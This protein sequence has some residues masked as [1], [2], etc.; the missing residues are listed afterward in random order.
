MRRAA[1]CDDSRQ[2]MVNLSLLA[3]F[4]VPA[5]GGWKHWLRGHRLSEELCEKRSTREIHFGLVDARGRLS[6]FILECIA[7]VQR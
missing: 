3:S 4:E 1:K 2:F 6:I 5:L 7:K